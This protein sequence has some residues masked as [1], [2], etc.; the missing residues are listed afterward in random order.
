MKEPKFTKEDIRT[1]II[2]FSIV[3]IIICAMAYVDHTHKKSRE[4]MI[5]R[6]QLEIALEKDRMQQIETEAN[7]LRPD[8]AYME[9]HS[10]SEQA[11]SAN[12]STSK[13]SDPD[14]YQDDLDYYLDD[15]EDIITYPEEIFDFNDD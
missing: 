14:R 8:S 5:K 15:P 7:R 1:Q 12:A 3:A 6:Q 4:D 10:A 9:N 2:A 11:S 13:A